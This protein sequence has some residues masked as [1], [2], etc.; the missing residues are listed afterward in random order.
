[1]RRTTKGKR[2]ADGKEKEERKIESIGKIST[3]RNTKEKSTERG[4][5]TRTG[6]PT[7][8]K[9]SKKSLR[10]IMILAIEVLKKEDRTKQSKIL[11]RQM[12]WLPNSCVKKVILTKGS[13]TGE[14]LP[15]ST[16]SIGASGSIEKER[17]NLS[18]MVKKSAQAIRHNHGMAQKSDS[19]SYANKKETGRGVG[20]KTRSKNG[21]SLYVGS[22]E[23]HSTRREWEGIGPNG[24][25]T[26][27]SDAVR[28]AEQASS[29]PDIS[30]LSGSERTDGISTKVMVQ[31]VNRSAKNFPGKMDQQ[32][33]QSNDRSVERKGKTNYHKGVRGKDRD[34]HLKKGKS[35]EKSKEKER[36]KYGNVNEQKHEDL[37]T[38]GANESE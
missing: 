36:E 23:T 2:R 35:K 7:K 25:I 1:M 28:R 20:S 38:P 17:N 4:K 16:E 30:S 18:G 10:R 21:K 22:A 11:N 14:M 19:I 6:M 37:D 8:F 12:S 9:L 3:T 32:L 24:R 5:R 13:N 34:Q 15:L 33:V 31:K 29:Y 27:S 26:P